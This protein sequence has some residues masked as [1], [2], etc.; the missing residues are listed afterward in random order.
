MKIKV[1]GSGC[2]WTKYNS[3]CYLIDDDI[4]VD[5]PN[6]AGKYFYSLGI[7]LGSISNILITHF[8]ADH[9]FDIPVYLLYKYKNG[10]KNANI[11]CSREGKKK[12]KKLYKLAFPHSGK[13][14]FKNTECN[15]NFDS[16]FKINDYMVTRILVDHGNLK[17]AYGYIFEKDNVKFGFT[18]DTT[19]C[20]NVRYM[21]SVC[22]Y[23]FCDCSCITG[24]HGHMGIDMLKELSS[25]YKD[26]KFVVSHLADETR[27]ELK[28]LKIK[29]I[30]ISED[31]ME[32][33]IKE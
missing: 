21:A 6:G 5:F 24:K 22:K 23:L 20:D 18:G 32:I 1:I 9:Y 15:F 17:P 33:D 31:G 10:I 27:K 3:A 14:V 2:M 11:Y 30:I 12:I 8:H 16:N 28:K 26:S 7:D 19:I 4:M 25:E 13:V 29:N